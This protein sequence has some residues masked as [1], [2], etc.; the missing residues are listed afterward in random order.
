MAAALPVLCSFVCNTHGPYVHH[1][2]KLQEG[3]AA[4]GSRTSASVGNSY[5]VQLAKMPTIKLASDT[6]VRG[7]TFL[8]GYTEP[9]LL[10]LHESAPTWGGR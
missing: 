10:L 8:H 2:A 5:L 4:K 9:V 7:M 3:A 6:A 1:Y